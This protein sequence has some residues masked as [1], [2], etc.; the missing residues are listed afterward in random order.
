MSF[1]GFTC[2]ACGRRFSTHHA[3][4]QHINDTDHYLASCDDCGRSF[5]SDFALQQHLDNSFAHQYDWEC[6]DCN[7]AFGTERALNQHNTDVHGHWDYDMHQLGNVSSNHTIQHSLSTNH[8]V[9]L[10]PTTGWATT[11]VQSS[12]SGIS[13]SFAVQI[14]VHLAPLAAGTSQSTRAGFQQSSANSFVMNT[15][16][17]TI[18]TNNNGSAIDLSSF[19]GA[20]FSGVSVNISD[21]HTLVAGVITKPDSR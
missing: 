5:N 1:Y 17:G 6:V 10:G 21:K 19:R 11:S 9:Q 16:Q 14:P 20:S 15:H 18:G 2:H 8:P 12:S 3:L 4:W 7:R 13:H